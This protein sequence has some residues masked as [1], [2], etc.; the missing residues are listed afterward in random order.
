MTQ[1]SALPIIDYNLGAQILGSE[2]IHNAK[3]MVAELVKMLPGDLE[4]LKAAFQQQDQQKLQEVAHYIS[5][6][7]SFCGTPRLTQAAKELDRSIKANAMPE[8]I[9][10]AYQNVCREIE[11]LLEEF[12]KTLK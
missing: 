5:G 6:G 11:L 8:A 10:T 12:P 9:T 2:D 3:L 7:S 4:K 1:Q